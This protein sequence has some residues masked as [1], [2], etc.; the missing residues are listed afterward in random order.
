MKQAKCHVPD[1]IT[2][3]ELNDY[4]HSNFQQSQPAVVPSHQ[5]LPNV[6]LKLS[7]TDVQ[8]E[9]SNYSVRVVLLKMFLFGC[10]KIFHL[11]LRMPLLFFLIGVWS[12]EGFLC[13]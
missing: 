9:L 8:V 4:F 12:R 11:S 5:D 1:S 3:E 2:S 10:T 13:V 7:V 6:N